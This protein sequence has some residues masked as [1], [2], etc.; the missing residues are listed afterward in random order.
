MYRILDKRA[1][2][3]LGVACLAALSALILA[4]CADPQVPRSA[5][6]AITLQRPVVLKEILL[7][8]NAVEYHTV[9]VFRM[10][11]VDMDD[12]AEIRGNIDARI[13]AATV[14]L[15]DRKVL[16]LTAVMTIRKYLYAQ[17]NNEGAA[18][19][20]VDWCV[21]EPDGTPVHKE[22]FY[23]TDSGLLFR[24][25]LV[26]ER[27]HEQVAERVVRTIAALSAGEPA[28]T[29]SVAGTY[30]NAGSAIASLPA[31]MTS[32]QY[33]TPVASADIPWY[34]ASGMEPEA[35]ARLR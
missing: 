20:A 9:R 21:A 3:W 5:E 30:D 15:A 7:A 2:R 4:A 31:Q 23:A 19:I 33:L 14:T 1:G 13:A 29:R 34:A 8:P 11:G 10:S 25:L 32:F 26:K 35:C 22:V 6:P 12:I 24:G 17:S 28:S 16:P 18:L 27:V